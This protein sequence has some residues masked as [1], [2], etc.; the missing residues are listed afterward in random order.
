MFIKT[1]MLTWMYLTELYSL[2]ILFCIFNYAYM[3]VHV[4]TF[5]G[6]SCQIF[7]MELELQ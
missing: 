6:Q 5:G 7:H 4:G 2:N 3:C 1:N